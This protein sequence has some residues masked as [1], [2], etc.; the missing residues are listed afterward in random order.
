MNITEIKIT[1]INIYYSKTTT[2]WRVKFKISSPVKLI[3][4]SKEVLELTRNSE[5]Y[6]KAAEFCNRKN[7]QLRKLRR[8]L[9]KS[10]GN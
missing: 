5:P 10:K 3:L 1:D 7:K 4:S 6:R 8:D 9:I 2:S